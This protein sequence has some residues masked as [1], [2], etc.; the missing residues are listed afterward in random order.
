MILEICWRLAAWKGVAALPAKKGCQSL[1]SQLAF[2]QRPMR[3]SGCFMEFRNI[4]VMVRLAAVLAKEARTAG[5]ATLV[6]TEAKAREATIRA[7]AIVM[8]VGVQE[9]EDV[10]GDGGRQEETGEPRREIRA[11]GRR[12]NRKLVDCASGG[13]K[14]FDGGRPNS[15]S[16]FRAWTTTCYQPTLSE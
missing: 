2:I 4:L 8:N 7:E 5:R 13:K 9:G 6:P 14:S 1:L 3:C 11:G 12:K 15:C 16:G 10:V